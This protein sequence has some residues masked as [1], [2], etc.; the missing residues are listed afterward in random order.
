VLLS[1]VLLGERLTMNRIAG[2]LLIVGGVVAL[3]RLGRGRASV[4][5]E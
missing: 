2:G 1:A 4:G 3:Q 5:G